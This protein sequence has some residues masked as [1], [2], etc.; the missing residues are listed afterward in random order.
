MRK[1]LGRDFYLQPTFKV[2]KKILGKYLVRKF[3]KKK[4][5]GRIVEVEVYLGPKDRASHA[6]GGRLTLRNRAEYL[7]GGH[8]YIYLVYGKYWQ[9]NI[10]TFESGK[11]ECILIR[12]LEVKNKPKNFVN[13]P[14]KVCRY[15][16]LNQSFYGEDLVTSKRIWLED[17]GEIIKKSDILETARIGI[18]YAGNY[19]ARRKWRFVLKSFLKK[20]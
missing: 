16:K 10:S 9:L 3:R 14:G 19:W 8:L 6:Y 2:A 15:L 11:P 1:R 7:L 20:K 13:G 12:S 17:R 4:L 5:I 18:E